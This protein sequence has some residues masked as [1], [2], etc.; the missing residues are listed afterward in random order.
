M[1]KTLFFAFL[2]IVLTSLLGVKI[3]RLG[4]VFLPPHH[5]FWSAEN[6]AENRRR[7]DHRMNLLKAEHR[8]AVD[9][10]IRRRLDA[11][12]ALAAIEEKNQQIARY[13]TET[14]AAARGWSYLNRLGRRTEAEEQNDLLLRRHL[15]AL[16]ETASLYADWALYFGDSVE[17]H[18]EP[19]PFVPFEPSVLPE[20]SPAYWLPT[21]YRFLNGIQFSP[22]EVIEDA[23]D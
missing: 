21:P 5:V 16:R 17:A 3:F 20:E 9:R 19:V 15:Y 13:L 2:L 22:E 4:H 18:L 11:D 8:Q 14:C 1:K 10:A 6:T 7:D 23:R 12:A